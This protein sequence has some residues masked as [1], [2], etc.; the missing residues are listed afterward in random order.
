M[1][2]KPDWQELLH[3]FIDSK[4]TAAFTWNANDCALFAA[5][6]VL[7]MTGDDL[8]A[9]YRGKYTDE[10]GATAAIASNT[11]IENGTVEDVANKTGLEPVT[12]PLFL[13]RGDVALYEGAEGK[14]RGIVALNGIHALFMGQSGLH[15][16]PIRRCLK[17]WRV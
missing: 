16:I 3:A 13:Q 15:K 5:E 4:Q 7:T 11:G 12:N 6:A 14:A 10:A 17:G 2:R 1:T 9:D 8:G